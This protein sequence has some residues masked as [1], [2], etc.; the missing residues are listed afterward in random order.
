MAKHRLHDMIMGKRPPGASTPAP[1]D[2]HEEGSSHEVGHET[3]PAHRVVQELIHAVHGKDVKGAHA[4]FKAL[5]G[6]FESQPHEENESEDAYADGGVID[7]EVHREGDDD[8]GPMRA[9]KPPFSQENADEES[10]DG[11]PMKARTPPFHED[12]EGDDE[13]P[14]PHRKKKS[15]FQ[16]YGRY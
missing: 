3:H 5:H 6:Y 4:A 1:T 13:P 7:A 8:G 2:P 16:G 12:W 15:L 14:T 10:N 11:G 9:K